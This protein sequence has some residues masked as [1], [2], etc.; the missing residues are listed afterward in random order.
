[1]Y[2]NRIQNPQK[3]LGLQIEYFKCMEGVDQDIKLIEER[4]G[5]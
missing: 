2:V 4:M 5:N 1:M 3:E